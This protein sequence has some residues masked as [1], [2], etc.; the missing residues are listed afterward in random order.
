[1]LEDLFNIG[2]I[3]NGV[4]SFNPP[5][6]MNLNFWKN[7]ITDR[8]AIV[9]EPSNVENISIYFIAENSSDNNKINKLFDEKFSKKGYKL[10]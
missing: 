5:L 9:K 1:M 10:L 4:V 6:L 8:K 3:D 2:V 7:N